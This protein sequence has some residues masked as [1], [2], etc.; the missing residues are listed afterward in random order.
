MTRGKGKR[1]R[2]THYLVIVHNYNI[3]VLEFFEI[4]SP[5]IRRGAAASDPINP[6]KEKDAAGQE[7]QR[8]TKR[9]AP[10]GRR[11]TQSA[12]SD[13]QRGALFGR[14]I[15]YRA[16]PPAASSRRAARRTACR[17]AAAR[18]CA[19]EGDPEVGSVAAVSRV[20][21]G[22]E[23]SG[24]LALLPLR[25]VRWAGRQWAPARRSVRDSTSSH[26]IPSHRIPFVRCRRRSSRRHYRSVS[27]EQKAAA[28]NAL[29][30]S[31]HRDGSAAPVAQLAE[32]TSKM[33]AAAVSANELDCTVV[34]CTVRRICTAMCSM[35]AN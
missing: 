5:G 10:T 16:A 32:Q 6:I 28:A 13:A 22:A 24:G 17:A 29:Q 2:Y 14:R 4:G 25:G 18:A 30:R 26:R 35:C 20:A 15:A 19:T 11:R 8:R 31:W 12:Q 9:A 27:T 1:D 3:S 33:R 23:R 7:L 21:C 34:Y